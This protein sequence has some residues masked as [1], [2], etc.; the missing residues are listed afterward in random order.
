MGS[1]VQTASPGKLNVKTESP[2]SSG[3]ILVLVC[4][5][6]QYL[7]VFWVFRS[8]SGYFQV[9]QS[10]CKG[11]HI[12]DHFSSF[13][14]CWLMLFTEVSPLAQTYSYATANS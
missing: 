6:F 4:F 2:L 8:F 9:I 12:H 1:G 11:I 10:F 3:Y 7:V 5:W 13:S 14:E